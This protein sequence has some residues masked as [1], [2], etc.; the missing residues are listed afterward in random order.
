M[1][2]LIATLNRTGRELFLVDNYGTET[3]SL[4]E[5]YTRKVTL[6]RYAGGDQLVQY[7]IKNHKLR[8]GAD[9]TVFGIITFP[10][11]TLLQ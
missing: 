10:I 3:I 11:V 8:D 4:S 5:I 6:E 9:K 2:G 1:N 7:W